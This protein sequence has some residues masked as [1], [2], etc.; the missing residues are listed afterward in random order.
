MKPISDEDLILY[1]YGEAS[2]DREIERQLESSAE[3]RQRFETLRRLLDTVAGQEVPE[4]HPAYGSRI[5]HRVAPQIE[6]ASSPAGA[7]PAPT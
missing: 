3:L 1:Y 5:W 4:P 6:R 2:D 7:C